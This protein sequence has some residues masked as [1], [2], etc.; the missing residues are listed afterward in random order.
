M[1]NIKMKNIIL[2]KV[3]PFSVI[4]LFL[5]Q[6]F[7]IS[8]EP[9]IIN[10]ATATDGVTVTLVVDPGLTITTP[11]DVSM[12]PNISMS[13]NG[14]IGSAVWTVKTN[15]PAGYTLNVKASASPALVSGGNSFADYTEA[16]NGTPEVWDVTSAKEFGFSAYGNNTA[17]ATWGTGSSC[18]SGG[19]PAGTMKYVGFETT[20]KAIATLNTVTPVAGVATTLCLAAEQSEVYAQSGTYTATITATA[21]TI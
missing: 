7:Y 20:D 3:L 15:A 13:A 10:A 4:S 17:T 8:N 11:A 2:K 19:V 1:A 6:I 9:N 5:F 21:V 14:S 12:S 16:S 18:G